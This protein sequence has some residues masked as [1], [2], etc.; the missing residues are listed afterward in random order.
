MAGDGEPVANSDGELETESSG[1]TD[2]DAFP[3]SLE[4][5]VAFTTA[6]A[7]IQPNKDFYLGS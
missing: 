2:K 4:Q 3:C 7:I 5:E 6:N 1:I